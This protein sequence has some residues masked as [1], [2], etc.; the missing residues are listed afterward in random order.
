MAFRLDPSKILLG[1]QRELGKATR[2]AN[3]VLERLGSGLRINRASD[4]AAGLA[5]AEGLRADSRILN[6]ALR[7]INDG[8]SMLSIAEGS[9]KELFPAQWDPKLGIHVT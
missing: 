9:L 1:P 7:N 8:V 3:K 6:Q 5:I 2:D 4:D